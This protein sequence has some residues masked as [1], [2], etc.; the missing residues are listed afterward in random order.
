MLTRL[1]GGV[2]IFMCRRL[3]RG[4]VPRRLRYIPQPVVDSP[5]ATDATRP[6]LFEADSP[7]VSTLWAQLTRHKDITYR[8]QEDIQTPPKHRA[9]SNY[10]AAS[11]RYNHASY[12]TPEPTP[13]S[14]ATCNLGCDKRLIQPP[15]HGSTAASGAKNSI[16]API[17]STGCLATVGWPD[18]CAER[19]TMGGGMRHCC[20]SSCRTRLPN[21]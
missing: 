1:W 12:S 11:R 6:K 16:V 8:Q 21:E 10:R 3:R 15:A 13:T 20:R 17:C 7:T 19:D 9:D 4:A 18:T 2:C 5:S 14:P